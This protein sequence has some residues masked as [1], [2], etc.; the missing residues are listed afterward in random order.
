MN[1][2]DYTKLVKCMAPGFDIIWY[3]YG[4]AVDAICWALIISY[5]IF[6]ILLDIQQ[7]KSFEIST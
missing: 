2:E 4:T 7:K 5:Y 1:N 6:S 3:T